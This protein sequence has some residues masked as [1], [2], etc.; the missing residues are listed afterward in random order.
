MPPLG[1]GGRAAGRR[2]AARSSHP[3]WVALCRSP[4]RLAGLPGHLGR[5]G[6]RVASGHWALLTPSHP[7]QPCSVP[8]GAPSLFAPSPGPLVLRALCCP[9]TIAPG[10]WSAVLPHLMHSSVVP[11]PTHRHRCSS[12]HEP[13]MAPRSPSPQPVVDQSRAFEPLYR[14]TLKPHCTAGSCSNNLPDF[15]LSLF[16]SSFTSF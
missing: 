16:L 11:G 7:P 4:G 15:F 9:L 3:V 10:S 14:L 12:A 6:V 13:S 8:V 1:A 5:E 2:P